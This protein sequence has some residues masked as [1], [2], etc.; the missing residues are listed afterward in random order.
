M[1]IV[2]NVNIVAPKI[3]GEHKSVTIANE[4]QSAEGVRLL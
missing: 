1:I 4:A 3:A 2:Y